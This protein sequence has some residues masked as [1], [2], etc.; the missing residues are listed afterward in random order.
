MENQKQQR[1]SD[2]TEAVENGTYLV[3]RGETVRI[4]TCEV[5]D[6]QVIVSDPNSGEQSSI[7]I[8]DLVQDDG[9]KVLALFPIFDNS[10]EDPV[11]VNITACRSAIDR[12]KQSAI[13]I[14][15]TMNTLRYDET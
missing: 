15:S 4:D 12:V 2:A 11:L 9:F 3:Y 14:L 10:K 1:L 5:E 7:D 8:S 13:D 6:G